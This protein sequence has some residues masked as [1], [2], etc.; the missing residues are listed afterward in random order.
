MDTNLNKTFRV[1]ILI[2]FAV[3][4]L[5]GGAYRFRGILRRAFFV[6][7]SLS[8]MRLSDASNGKERA[9]CEGKK[10]CLVVYV[11]PW[12]PACKGQLPF[13]KEVDST[14]KAYPGFGLEVIIGWDKRSRLLEMAQ[15]L[16]V[17]SLLDDRG[18]F[19]TAASLS[20]VPSWYLFSNGT[21]KKALTPFGYSAAEF[22]EQALRAG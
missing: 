6:P 15:S 20:S 17:H 14:V 19:A 22:A 12:C 7:V 5:F 16:G 4:F 21:L 2:S 11:S 10:V 13:I 8:E 9:I 1:I 3:F 18:S